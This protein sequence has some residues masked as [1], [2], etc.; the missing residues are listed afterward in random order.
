MKKNGIILSALAGVAIMPSLCAKESGDKVN[1]L[2]IMCD[3]HA[4]QAISAYGH[5]ISKVAPTPN[6]DRLA[7]NGMLFTRAYVENSISTPSRATLLTGKYS[8]LHGQTRLGGSTFLEDQIVFPELL[9]QAGYQTAVVGKWHLPIQPRGFDY[10]KLLKGQ[11]NYY[12]PAF[13]TPDSNG[14]Y[15]QQQGYVADIITDGAINWIDARDKEKPFCLLLHHKSPHRN[16]MPDIKYLELYENIDIPYPE[17]LFDNYDTRSS[18]AKSQQM[19]IVDDMT[20]DSDLKVWKSG[21]PTK[22]GGLGDIQGEYTRMSPEQQQ[23]W[24]KVYDPR[25]EE[26]LAANLQGEE[27][28]KW[29][30]QR[31][32][33]DYLRC[34]KSVDDQVGRVLD[35]LETNSLL[36]NT[37]IVYTSDQ[38]F[39]MGEHGWFD[40]RF[41]YEESFRTPLLISYPKMIKGGSKC[42]ALVQNIDF[43][44]TILDMAGV[45][46]PEIMCGTSIKPLMGGKV[47]DDWRNDLYYH[48][49]DYPAIHMVRKHDGVIADR[50]K[51]I[52]YYGNG[53]RKDAGVNMDDW[54]FY[55]LKKDPSEVNNAYKD[56]KYKADIEHLKKRLDYYR[57]TYSVKEY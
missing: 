2:Y 16:W 3:D 32:L 25:N 12:N 15:V 57:Q 55:D 44:P 47:P 4:Y 56:P 34:V 38:G 37:I 40:K 39:Y 1:I 30:Y 24:S 9:Q 6:I 11:G 31:Y 27:L 21:Q 49:Y 33:K 17:T 18:A 20:L 26:F 43:A 54:E 48:Y 51:L 52:H 42:P 5:P 29:K 19:S 13:M 23:A 10:Y 28:V 45:D 53:D 7:K 35:Y 41:M 14:E 46:V 36:D 22:K 50:Y 8:H